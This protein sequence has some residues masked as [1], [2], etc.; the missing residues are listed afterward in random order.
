M[1]IRKLFVVATI[2]FACALFPPTSASAFFSEIAVRP[3]KD[4]AGPSHIFR[5]HA[6]LLAVVDPL[7]GKVI[8]LAPGATSPTKSAKL[9]PGTRPWRL[10][11]LPDRVALIDEAQNTRV[12]IP[13]DVEQWPG[14]LQAIAHSRNDRQFK[15]PPVRRNAGDRLTLRPAKGRSALS[16]H[17]IGPHYLASVRELEGGRDGNRYVLWK[18][19]Y[20]SEPESSQSR[21]RKIQV[22]VYVGRFDRRRH[23]SGIV[24]LPLERMSRLGFD[25]AAILPDGSVGLLA[26][27]DKKPFTISSLPFAVPSPQQAQGG[28][29]RRS[30]AA[31]PTPGEPRPLLESQ[32][33]TIIDP[34][35]EP[36]P[37]Q[38]AQNVE[39]AADRLSRA[40]FRSAMDAY[41]DHLWTV[42]AENLRN[43]C[44]AAVLSDGPISCSE[45]QAAKFVLPPRQ[46][47]SPPPGV[48]RGVSYNWGGADTVAGY[49]DKLA[50]GYA[51]GNIGGTYWTAERDQLSAGVDCSGFVSNVWRIGEHVDSAKLDQFSVPLARLSELRIGDA[52]L[53]AG[54]HVVLYRRQV[55]QDGA[56][57]S[58][59]V[60]E[61]ASRCGSV[62]DSIYEI[63][64][65]HNYTLRRSN[66]LQ[67][68]RN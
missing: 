55:L 26:S 35:E 33:A 32:P 67:S 17:A 53:L 20:F 36:P 12:E 8:A 15:A 24:R 27:L 29:S 61:A 34:G 47:T 54:N 4:G 19:M 50:R 51:A 48:L 59:H 18:E 9:P 68:V 40:S 23:L 28:R 64:R 45:Q 25:Y 11:G 58:I 16:V 37:L 5:L 43:P 7:E 49:D 44:K 31:A 21:T 30:W 57:L 10:V 60:T 3:S 63:D 38:S 6:G 22:E 42:R 52:L 56:S 14:E 65:F 46:A 66:S 1:S 39:T 2:L 41:R 62:C 13:R